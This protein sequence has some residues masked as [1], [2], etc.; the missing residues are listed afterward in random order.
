VHE[1]SIACAV[2]DLAARAAG[3]ASVDEV[4]V[5][6]GA[7]SGVVPDALVFAFDVAAAGTVCEGGRLLVEAVPVA[8]R[9]GGCGR[10]SDL[11]E[12][13]RFRCPACGVPTPDVVRGRELEVVS[14]TLREESHAG[15][16]R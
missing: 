4:R 6:V 10:E 9:C 5:R 16:C 7:L 1:L 12:P 14:I 2:V 15:A 11:A 13:L 8:V 3:D